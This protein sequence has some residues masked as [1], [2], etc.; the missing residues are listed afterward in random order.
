MLLDPE[1]TFLLHQPVQ[2]ELHRQE[3][4]EGGLLVLGPS[5]QRREHERH[6][7]EH[8]PGIADDEGADRG[9]EDDD[10]LE[11]LPEDA[12]LAAHRRVAA[13]GADADDD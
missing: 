7:L 2:G 5:H 10:E 9:A 12:Q 11:R 6:G 3:L 4:D 13:E 8:R 1:H